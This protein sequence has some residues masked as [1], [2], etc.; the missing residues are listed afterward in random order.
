VAEG[1]FVAV[2]CGGRAERGVAFGD[3]ILVKLVQ[4]VDGKPFSSE[5]DTSRV[6]SC[7]ARRRTNLLM[8]QILL[9]CGW[10]MVERRKYGE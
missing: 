3:L 7:K 9:K 4:H 10:W 8:V 5:K 2:V 6:V 1:D